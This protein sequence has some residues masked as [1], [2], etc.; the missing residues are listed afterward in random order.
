M[1]VSRANRLKLRG[2][3]LTCAA[4]LLIYSQLGSEENT[5]LSSSR[6]SSGTKTIEKDI[7]IDLE[8]K[9]EVNQKAASASRPSSSSSITLTSNQSTIQHLYDNLPTRQ[10]TIWT[11]DFPCYTKRPVGIQYIKIKKSASTTTHEVTQRIAYRKFQEKFNVADSSDNDD[12]NDNSKQKQ[13]EFGKRCNEISQHI[14]A[15]KMMQA[16]GTKM[17][18]KPHIL[19]T[20]LR[21]PTSRY[22]SQFFYHDVS[23]RNITVSLHNFQKYAFP[24]EENQDVPDIDEKY[25]SNMGG[26]Q[27]NYATTRGK[28]IYPKM[29]EFTYWNP[30]QPSLVQNVTLL[31]HRIQELLNRYTFFGIVE[32]Y[33][34]SLVAMTFLFH[35]SVGDVL[36]WRNRISGGYDYRFNTCNPLVKSYKT[37]DMKE[38]FDS[39]EWKARIAGDFMFYASANASLDLTIEH[40]IGREKFE[41]R[42]EQFKALLIL[43]EEKCV[44]F[45]ACSSDGHRKPDRKKQHYACLD[46]VY[47]E[48]RSKNGLV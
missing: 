8:Q 29:D 2:V 22:I 33:D 25:Y 45:E 36:Y 20:F 35:L 5:L 47:D 40:V 10:Y 19:F 21:E 1:R 28:Y 17:K 27:L 44:G 32:R 26:F 34:E 14:P 6:K 48:Y 18:F 12:D 23:Y 3:L 38:Y 31:Q 46:D 43:V 7:P 24:N 4:F 41:N 9:S 13:V 42:L 16:Y 39:E 30:Q 15:Y 37:E 11:G